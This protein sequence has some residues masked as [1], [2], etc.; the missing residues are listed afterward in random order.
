M[1]HKKNPIQEAKDFLERT[2]DDY[3]KARRLL[4]AVLK[5]IEK[6]EEVTHDHYVVRYKDSKEPA[7]YQSQTFVLASSLKEAGELVLANYSAEKILFVGKMI[8]WSKIEK[9]E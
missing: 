9:G 3:T 1:D 4:V 8:H 7:G 5:E 6:K 2:K